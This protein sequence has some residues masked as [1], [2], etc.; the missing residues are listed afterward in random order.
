MKMLQTMKRAA[1]ATAKKSKYFSTVIDPTKTV[2]TLT[3]NPKVRNLVRISRRKIWFCCKLHFLFRHSMICLGPKARRLI[4]HP[5][6][7]CSNE[8]LLLGNRSSVIMYRICC[9]V[10]LAVLL[11]LRGLIACIKH[12]YIVESSHEL[13]FFMG[14]EVKCVTVC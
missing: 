6:G 3:T 1:L 4:W 11:A 2:I 12:F 10:L 5:L 8:G 7:S 13:N 14:Y 9:S